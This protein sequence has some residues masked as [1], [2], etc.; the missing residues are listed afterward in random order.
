MLSFFP[1]PS[2]LCVCVGLIVDDLL[3]THR[4]SSAGGGIERTVVYIGDGGGDWCPSARLSTD[5]VVL[6]RGGGEFGLEKRCDL[7]LGGGD[8]CVCARAHVWC[9]ALTCPNPCV[10][11][12]TRLRSPGGEIAARVIYWETYEDLEAA[13]NG[14]LARVADPST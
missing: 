7:I 9:V 13:I 6:A 10:H 4:A 1:S 14:L 8:V 3:A 5:D 12:L 11:P 2:S